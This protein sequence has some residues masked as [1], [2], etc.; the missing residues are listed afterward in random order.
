[1]VN[2]WSGLAAAGGE[3]ARRGGASGA[4]SLFAALLR[5]DAAGEAKGGAGDRATGFLIDKLGL[6]G[7]VAPSA[8]QPGLVEAAITGF[9]NLKSELPGLKVKDSPRPD[10]ISPE[11]AATG[12]KYLGFGLAA[13]GD[14]SRIGPDWREVG[15]SEI[16]GVSL[17]NPKSGLQARLYENSVT[18]EVV[19]AFRGTDGGDRFADVK[20]DILGAFGFAPQGGVE[21]IEIGRALKQTYGDRLTITGHS[22][23]GGYAAAAGLASGTKTYAFD[24]PGFGARTRALI[25]EDVIRRNQHLITNFNGQG[26]FVNDADRNSDAESLGGPLIG[27]S[28]FYATNQISLLGPLQK[29]A[30]INIAISHMPH[31]QYEELA[32]LATGQPDRTNDIVDTILYSLNKA[33]GKRA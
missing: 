24:P 21:A 20:A 1:M 23:G 32:T 14:D 26:N 19:L 3:L 9:Q 29:F 11:L 13:Y 31:L 22:L 15:P 5:E 27:R 17:N 2:F 33:R 12:Q 30:P 25:G 10:A 16:P 7:V 4:P 18:K 8:R 28:Y 6:G